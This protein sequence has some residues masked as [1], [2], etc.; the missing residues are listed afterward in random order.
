[1]NHIPYCCVE[2]LKYKACNEVGT[3]S[4]GL[5]D[6]G[7]QCHLLC[8]ADSWRM[9]PSRIQYLPGAIMQSARCKTKYCWFDRVTYVPIDFRA[10]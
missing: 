8:I 5:S 4:V 6:V 7:C 2:S 1:M 10:G 3:R 9:S